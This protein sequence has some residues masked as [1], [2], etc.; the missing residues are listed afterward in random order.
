MANYGLSIS[1]GAQHI[2]E[3]ALLKSVFPVG[4]WTSSDQYLPVAK[5]LWRQGNDEGDQMFTLPTLSTVDP[6]LYSLGP[7]I[8]E[9]EYST[10]MYALSPLSV[11]PSCSHQ[12]KGGKKYLRTYYRFEPFNLFRSDTRLAD[13]PFDG[14]K[15]I[16]KAELVLRSDTYLTDGFKGPTFTAKLKLLKCQFGHA[17]AKYR[18]NASIETDYVL[19]NEPLNLRSGLRD[20]R[21][22]LITSWWV[23]LPEVSPHR[24]RIA[25]R[26]NLG[27]KAQH[28][29]PQERPTTMEEY[30]RF[31]KTEINVECEDRSVDPR[32]FVYATDRI[33]QNIKKQLEELPVAEM[34]SLLSAQQWAEYNRACGSHGVIDPC[35]QFHTPGTPVIV[36]TEE[37]PAFPIATHQEECM[38]QFVA[39]LTDRRLSP[40]TVYNKAVDNNFV[41]IVPLA[42]PQSIR[43]R[44]GNENNF[45]W[46]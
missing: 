27:T 21:H 37:P 22:K 24:Y 42:A 46:E 11:Q 4:K 8:N 19:P 39:R 6:F 12:W 44:Y 45:E 34:N 32:L 25:V 9:V 17:G 15:H 36:C 41:E 7:L 30:K 16:V 43:Q 5:E 2:K 38:R 31:P 35:R 18:L 10:N 23:V 33:Y 20:T 29:Q 26:H 1:F 28:R 3:N 14:Y 40:H 13:F